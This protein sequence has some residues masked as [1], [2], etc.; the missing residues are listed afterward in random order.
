MFLRPEPSNVFHPYSD[1]LT[2]NASNIP[3]YS[4]NEVLSEKIRALI[5][6]SYTAP[7]DYF[8]IW[9]LSKNVGNID[10]NEVVRGFQQ[11]IEY[12]NL[13]FSGIEQIINNRNDKIL[14]SAWKNSL[15]H[16]VGKGQ[17]PKY[18]EVQSD[19]WSLFTNIF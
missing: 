19:L 4:I 5:Q 13:I 16:Q 18:E 2:D 3:I 17:L 6:R 1:K 8:D 11:K 12:K 7:R 10:W 15:E 9:C 14:K